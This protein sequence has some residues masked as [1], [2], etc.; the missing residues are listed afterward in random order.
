MYYLCGAGLSLVRLMSKLRCHPDAVQA[1]L[2]KEVAAYRTYL[3]L[4]KAGVSVQEVVERASS[5]AEAVRQLALLVDELE[6]PEPEP[7]EQDAVQ[8]PREAGVP[9]SDGT[10]EA[11]QKPEDASELVS[12]ASLVQTRV[13]AEVLA[14]LEDAAGPQSRSPFRIGQSAFNERR[15]FWETRI[16]AGSA[17]SL[18]QTDSGA[19]DSASEDMQPVVGPPAVQALVEAGAGDDKLSVFS[20]EADSDTLRGRSSDDLSP[21]TPT[22]SAEE[23]ML[24]GLP[25]AD[26]VEP[27]AG[28]SGV[29]EAGWSQGPRHPCPT[30][31]LGKLSYLR[32]F[33]RSRGAQGAQ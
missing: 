32:R 8:A 20:S 15:R 1:Q 24:M 22:S 17:S 10:L 19:W 21:S 5:Q 23:D 27:H 12:D 31:S 11:A 30:P 28:S 16:A 2:D 3:L 6:Q 7:A 25:N 14:E 18:V 9:A 4:K 29:E 13:E 33:G 26:A